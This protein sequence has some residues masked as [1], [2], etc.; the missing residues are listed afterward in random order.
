MKYIFLTLALILVSV[1][2]LS[3]SIPDTTEYDEIMQLSV[4]ILNKEKPIDTGGISYVNFR[5]NYYDSIEHPYTITLEHRVYQYDSA[6][7]GDSALM[8]TDWWTNGSELTLD[9]NL[10]VLGDTAIDSLSFRYK[11]DYLPFTFRTLILSVNGDSGELISR[12][13]LMVYFTPYSTLEIWSYDDFHLLYRDWDNPDDGLLTSLR[14]TINKDSI[15]TSNLTQSEF[16]KDSIEIQWLSFEG[17]GYSIPM[18][19]L[20]DPDSSE[21]MNGVLGKADG[22]SV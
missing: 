9:T 17:L 20:D 4:E 7:Q 21:V 1:V 11:N 18:K 22:C 6:W 10:H 2:Q 13:L 12:Q 3:A 16:V 14:D 8:S 19:G 5:I 15:P